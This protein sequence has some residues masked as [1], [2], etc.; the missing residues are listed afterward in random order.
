MTTLRDDATARAERSGRFGQSTGL[1]PRRVGVERRIV[2]IQRRAVRADDLP[3]VAHIEEDM[4]M[5][6]RGLGANAHELAGADLDDSD[7]RIVVEVR[8]D[9]FGHDFAWN[10]SLEFAFAGAATYRPLVGFHSRRIAGR[11]MEI[12]RSHPVWPW[13][14]AGIF[15]MAATALVPVG[16]E[17]WSMLAAADDPVAIADRGL[18]RA[19]DGTVAVRQIGA[20][21]DSDDPELAQSFVELADDRGVTLPVDLKQRVQAAVDQANSAGATAARF[22]GGLITGEPKDATEL[23]GTALGDLFVFGDIRDAVREGGRYVSGEAYDPLILGLAGAGI[24]ITAG[25]YATAGV[26]AP[27]RL[28]LTVLKAARKTGQLGGAMGRWLGRSLRNV[29]AAGP[30]V[31]TRAGPEAVKIEMAE[32][33]VR[34]VGDVGIVQAKAG[35]RAAFDGLKLAESPREMSRIAALAEKKG[36]KTRAILKMLGRGAILLSVASLNLAGWILGAILTLF[37]L[38]SSTK[39]AVER[40]T[41]RYLDRRKIRAAREVAAREAEIAPAFA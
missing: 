16:I 29:A 24:A 8:D 38:V 20:A 18:S 7:T 1:W 23:A 27:A 26:A 21:L 13:L 10:F 5:I 41:Q 36:G 19:F 3:I 35:M 4:R 22:A 39:A 28:G 34:L 31:A 2:P 15:A 11:E 14:A 33:L 32:G 9:M 30:K 6:V 37:G 40:M 12:V 25:T 17:G